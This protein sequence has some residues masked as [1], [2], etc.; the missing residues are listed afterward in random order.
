METSSKLKRSTNGEN[1]LLLDSENPHLRNILPHRPTTINPNLLDMSIDENQNFDKPIAIVIPGLS[2]CSKDRYVKDTC[3]AIYQY[4]GFLP[5]V[6]N[7]R[8]YSDVPVTGMYPLCKG[9]H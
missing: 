2:S 3:K 7:R 1:Q 5:I 9:R 8:G 4:T 6:M